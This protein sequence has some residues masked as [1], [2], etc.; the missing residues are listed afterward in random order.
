VL[1]HLPL[2]PQPP[3]WD[4]NSARI[5]LG[6]SSLARLKLVARKVHS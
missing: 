6:T 4:P 2:L 1:W 5:P 3:T